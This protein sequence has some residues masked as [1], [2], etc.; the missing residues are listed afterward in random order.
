MKSRLPGSPL[1]NVIDKPER[2]LWSR[3]SNLK[4]IG[5]LPFMGSGTHPSL[6]LFAPDSSCTP[7]PQI[8]EG[9]YWIDARRNRAS[10]TAGTTRSSVLNGTTM[11]LTIQLYDN[12]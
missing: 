7:A 10:L 9:P 12:N 4:A 6:Q 2:A 5:L 8:A 1:F 3:R 11:S